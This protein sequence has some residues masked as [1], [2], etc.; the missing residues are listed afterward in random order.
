M[1]IDRIFDLNARVRRKS[2]LFLGPR[3][4][5]KSTLLRH[6]DKKTLYID[7]LDPDDY[8]PLTREPARLKDLIKSHNFSVSHKTVIIDEIQ[9]LPEL[10]DL[11]HLMIE[12]DKSLRF[13][14]TGSS[15][16]K[17]RK[18]GMN[19]LGGRASLQYF[20]PLVS[21][22]LRL[23]KG[24]SRL[25]G[26]LLRLGGLPSVIL[27]DDPWHALKDYVGLYLREEIQAEALTRSLGNF[28][29]FLQ[30]AAIS[31]A[32]QLNY[33]EVANDAQLPART[34][35]DYFQVLEDTLVGCLVPPFN[36]KETRKFVATPKFYFF[37][38]GVANYLTGRKN[39]A[40]KTI[41]YGKALEHFIFCELRAYIGINNLDAEIFYCRTQTGREIDF[42]I[43]SEDKRI[44]I[45][46]KSSSSLA[47]KVLRSMS[48][49]AEE[50]GINK[51]IIVC[52]E[53]RK[54]LTED[55]VVVFP[56]EVFLNALWQGGVF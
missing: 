21:E 41:E 27:S 25:W 20:F 16:R 6:F 28:S 33:E 26:D 45:E 12:Q 2:L 49:F 14:L 43:K 23:T 19:L 39:L 38:T 55:G 17:L 36:P 7:L 32:E 5:G 37:D 48:S 15:A 42:I 1:Y 11:V 4:T 56:V 52:Q 40:N 31:N 50:L 44:A 22:E 34:V 24:H 9:K 29:R 18:G 10:M 3:Q 47:Q 51:K 53:P 8:L 54:R 30:T 35:R 46:V 13:I